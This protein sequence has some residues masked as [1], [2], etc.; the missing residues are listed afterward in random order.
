LFWWKNNEKVLMEKLVDK[1]RKEDKEYA[2]GK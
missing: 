1:N 2:L